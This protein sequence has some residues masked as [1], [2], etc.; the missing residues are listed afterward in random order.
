MNNQKMFKNT[1][2]S[3]IHF[4]YVKN[5]PVKEWLCI[6]FLV[7]ALPETSCMENAI[8]M[9]SDQTKTIVVQKKHYSVQEFRVEKRS[10]MAISIETAFLLSECKGCSP[11]HEILVKMLDYLRIGNQ[12]WLIQ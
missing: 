9:C 6:N 5:I 1:F 10:T 12:K 7:D 8:V 2:A 3:L 11:K 4:Q